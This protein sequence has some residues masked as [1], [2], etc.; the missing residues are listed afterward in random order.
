MPNAAAWSACWQNLLVG[1]SDATLPR[2]IVQSY[3]GVRHQRVTT[4]RRARR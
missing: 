3:E 2:P 4:R 1:V